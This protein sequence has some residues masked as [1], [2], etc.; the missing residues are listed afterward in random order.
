MYGN[1]AIESDEDIQAHIEVI[2]SFKPQV[3]K[4]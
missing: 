3:I 1:E 4:L 2:N